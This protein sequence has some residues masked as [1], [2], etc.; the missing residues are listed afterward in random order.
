MAELNVKHFNKILAHIRGDLKRLW[1]PWFG[2]RKGTEMALSEGLKNRDF[3]RC[4][5][6]C[7]FAGWSELLAT[8]RKDWKKLFSEDGDLS[9]DSSIEGERLGLTEDEYS[10]LFR[11]VNGSRRKQFDA[12]RERLRGIIANRVAQGEVGAKKIRV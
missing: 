12:V 9:I 10:I 5:T 1:M 4:G 6:A 7:C 11:S 2:V 3:A 8:P